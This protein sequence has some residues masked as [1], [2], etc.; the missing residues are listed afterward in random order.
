MTTNLDL[1]RELS[2]LVRELQQNN[3]DLKRENRRLNQDMNMVMNKHYD[4][5]RGIKSCIDVRKLID[6]LHSI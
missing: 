6:V 3:R 2:K 4:L 1:L 5:V